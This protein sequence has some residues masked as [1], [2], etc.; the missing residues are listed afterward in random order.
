MKLRQK[1]K[2]VR[3]F[4]DL[5]KVIKNPLHMKN[6]TNQGIMIS[7]FDMPITLRECTRSYTKYHIHSFLSYS[8][9]SSELGHSLSTLIQQQYRKAYIWLWIFLSG[10]LSSWNKWELLKRITHGIF[11]L[12]LKVIKEL[13][14]SGVHSEV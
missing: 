2:R 6:Q 8:N 3:L 14:A 9:L 4:L 12:F 1:H 7:L 10:R 11:V 5:K 13:G